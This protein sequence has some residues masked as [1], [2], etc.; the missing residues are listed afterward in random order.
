MAKQGK[1]L[2]DPVKGLENYEELFAKLT[3]PNRAI[4][5]SAK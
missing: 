1:L 2:T 3:N 4:K 5:L